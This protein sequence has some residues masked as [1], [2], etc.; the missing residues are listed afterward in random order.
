MSK[1]LLIVLGT[2][3]WLYFGTTFLMN[4]Q[5]AW[6]PPRQGEFAFG[7]ANLMVFLLYNVV[8]IVFLVVMGMIA[9]W[10]YEGRCKQ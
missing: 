5:W 9:L 3:A 6:Y 1:R 2:T 7:L 4:S 8:A 10:V